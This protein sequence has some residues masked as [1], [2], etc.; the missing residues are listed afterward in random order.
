MTRKRYQK[1]MYAWIATNL[2][3]MDGIGRVLKNVRKC[4][5]V[6]GTWELT[7]I[8]TPKNSYSEMWEHFTRIDNM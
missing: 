6:C 8:T 2:S 5:I 1:K 7:G 3:G 4:K